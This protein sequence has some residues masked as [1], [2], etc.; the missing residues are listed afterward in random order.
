MHC[1]FICCDISSVLF[2]LKDG[3]SIATLPGL[4]G[5]P[6]HRHTECPLILDLKLGVGNGI[7]FAG[8][9]QFQDQLLG[10]KVLCNTANRTAV[11]YL[12]ASDY[13]ICIT[14]R[15]KISPGFYKGLLSYKGY[16]Y[17]LD[18]FAG[19]DRSFRTWCVES[20]VSFP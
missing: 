15:P 9:G 19:T 12:E 14:T 1:A 6:W 3:K 18:V 8:E 16:L 5:F 2:A 7:C 4:L 13:I 11:M 10:V 17:D 20:D